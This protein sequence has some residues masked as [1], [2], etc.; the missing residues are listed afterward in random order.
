MEKSVA[1]VEEKGNHITE[2]KDMDKLKKLFFTGPRGQKQ[3]FF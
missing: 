3:E 1:F 2:N